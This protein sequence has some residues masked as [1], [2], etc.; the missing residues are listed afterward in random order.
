MEEYIEFNT[1]K[2]KNAV[3]DFEKQFFRLMI[4]SVYGKSME[5]LRKRISVKLINNTRDYVKCVSKPNFISQ[6]IF[7]KN[8]VAVRHIKSILTLD[9]PIYVGCS[10]LELSKY[11]ISI[12]SL[13]KINLM[14]N[15]CSQILIV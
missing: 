2:R 14:L 7:S 4:N 10:I 5:N 9:K 13:L 11:A 1:E 15:Y 3:S 6:K 8:F 12:M